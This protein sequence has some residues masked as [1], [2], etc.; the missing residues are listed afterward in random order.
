MF[1][2][3]STAS[4]TNLFSLGWQLGENGEFS[5][6]SNS[7]K[8]TKVPLI[9]H[10]PKLTQTS[11]L[12]NNLVELVDLFPT[13]VDLTQVSKSLLRCP[14]NKTTELC[15]EGRSL[16]PLIVSSVRQKVRK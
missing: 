6:F 10:I 9:M 1:Q 14:Q 8:A 7:E 13:L 2:P 4:A 12:T 11:Q 3:V 15:T 5:K 16:V